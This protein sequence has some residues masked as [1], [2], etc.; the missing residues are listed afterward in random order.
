MVCCFPL[1]RCSDCGAR[2]NQAT[3]EC[4]YNDHVCPGASLEQ[5]MTVINGV[6]R[7]IVNAGG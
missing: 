1:V 7:S 3:E 5:E 4:L 6:P 2:T